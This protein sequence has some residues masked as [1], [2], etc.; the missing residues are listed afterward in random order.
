MRP[1]PPI[2]SLLLALSLPVVAAA[3]PQDLSTEG[4]RSGYARTGRYAE[5]IALCDAFAT[6]HPDAVRCI[7]FGT[8]PEGAR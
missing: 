6:R 8:T 5:V 3:A 1:A 4:E 7:E 2:A